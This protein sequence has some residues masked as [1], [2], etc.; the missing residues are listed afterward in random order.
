MNDLYSGVAVNDV[1]KADY[2]DLQWAVDK[3]ISLKIM[4]THPGVTVNNDS[5]EK[6]MDAVFRGLLQ[7]GLGE[8]DDTV[9]KTF[10][11]AIDKVLKNNG[12]EVAAKSV[13]AL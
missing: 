13:P 1:Q 6:A 4:T 3:L 9:V 2:K 12:L 10:N 8:H 5:I 7:C 11:Q